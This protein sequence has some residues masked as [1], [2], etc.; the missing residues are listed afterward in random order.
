M[1]KCSRSLMS[2]SSERSCQTL[3]FLFYKSVPGH[4]EIFEEVS[5]GTLQPGDI[6]LFRSFSSSGRLGSSFI[7]AAVYC[8]DGEVIHF[9][10]TSSQSNEGRVSKEGLRAM[11]RERGKYLTRRKKGGIDLD[12]FYSKVREVMNSEAKYSLGSNNCIHF[13]LYLLGLADFYM[14]L[15]QI[16]NQG[17]SSSGVSTSP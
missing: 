11:K 16:Q 2:S 15:V 14:E 3:E 4:G 5:D 6:L 7:H 17:G 8:G 1:L 9:Q 10:D 12:D 13:A